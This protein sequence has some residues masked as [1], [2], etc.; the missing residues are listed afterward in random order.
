MNAHT[1]TTPPEP[2]TE[3]IRVVRIMDTDEV[4]AM[5]R[6]VLKVDDRPDPVIE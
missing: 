1:R 4:V 6:R 5:L 3:E 2:Q